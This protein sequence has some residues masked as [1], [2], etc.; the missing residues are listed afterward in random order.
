FT[1]TFLSRSAT[2]PREQRGTA[3][4]GLLNG[5]ACSVAACRGWARGVARAGR[6]GEYE[7]D[8]ADWRSP[9]L[10]IAPCTV[11]ELPAPIFL[12]EPRRG[13]QHSN[14]VDAAPEGFSPHVSTVSRAT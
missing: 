8:D 5:G 7:R 11:R 14:D 4:P 9:H 10:R 2:V 6:E 13:R 3:R 12:R 1:L